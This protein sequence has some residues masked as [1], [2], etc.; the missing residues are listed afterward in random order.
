ME[1]IH[2][3]VFQHTK[4]FV[5]I[6]LKLTFGVRDERAPREE[7]RGVALFYPLPSPLHLMVF[8]LFADLVLFDLLFC[9]FFML[10]VSRV[11]RSMH[12]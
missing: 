6:F 7:G 2:R 10:W 11:R 8:S 4:F 1:Y 3:F 9:S 5:C 12:F